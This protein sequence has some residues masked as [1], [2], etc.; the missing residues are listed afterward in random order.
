MV[1]NNNEV[2]DD[3]KSSAAAPIISAVILGAGIASLAFYYLRRPSNGRT[4]GQVEAY[5]HKCDK[6]VTELERR[7]LSA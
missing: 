1:E 2:E 6:S 4:H 3:K 5:L 7:L